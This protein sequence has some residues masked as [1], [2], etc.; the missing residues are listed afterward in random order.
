M[1]LLLPVFDVGCSRNAGSRQRD[2]S[3]SKTNAKEWTQ[4]VAII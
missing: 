4:L 1:L 3:T 2:S